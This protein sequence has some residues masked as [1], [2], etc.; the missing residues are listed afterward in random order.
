MD[1]EKKYEGRRNGEKKEEWKSKQES[2]EKT[3]RNNIMREIDTRKVTNRNTGKLREEIITS[4]SCND[5]FF[6]LLSSYQMRKRSS[7]D[8]HCILFLLLLSLPSF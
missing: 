4:I 5:F 7:R 6:L 8:Y 2:Y 1:E 3:V